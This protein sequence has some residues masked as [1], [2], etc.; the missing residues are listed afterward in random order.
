MAAA[1][2]R[3]GPPGASRDGGDDPGG[4]RHLQ[5]PVGL[6]EAFGGAAHGAAN[7]FGVVRLRSANRTRE[8]ARE[9]EL[10]LPPVLEVVVA[11]REVD[12]LD[13]ELDEA[14]RVQHIL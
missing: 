11:D 9:V 5:R 3:P 2:Y 10:R 1:G 14:R 4:S 12:A 6:H 13:A 8:G 7:G